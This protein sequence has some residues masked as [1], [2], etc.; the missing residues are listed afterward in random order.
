MTAVTASVV[1][2]GTQISVSSS[3]AKHTAPLF[4]Q[5]RITLPTT[6]TSVDTFTV[7]LYEN[8]GISRLLGLY[9]F[10]HT[11]ED[12]VI[13]EESAASSSVDRGVLTIT[14]NGTTLATKRALAVLGI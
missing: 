13:V 11:T 8:F 4:K 5:G 7:D 6:T 3:S 9:D 14:I 2:I 1:K 10:T 12:S